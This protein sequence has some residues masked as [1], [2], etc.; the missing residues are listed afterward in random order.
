MGRPDSAPRSCRSA[1]LE[2][3]V[4]GVVSEF[5]KDGRQ[6]GTTSVRDDSSGQKI[7]VRSYREPGK[8]SVISFLY[9]CSDEQSSALPV[10]GVLSPREQEIATLVS[11]GLTTKQIA[12]KAFVSENTVK[13]HLKRI[14]AKTDVHNRAELVQLIWSSRGT[15]A[16]A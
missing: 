9:E 1:S 14:F 13:Q 4:D 11:Q 12:Q 3:L 16:E 10:W 2:G 6:A 8:E 15:V 7:I 5:V